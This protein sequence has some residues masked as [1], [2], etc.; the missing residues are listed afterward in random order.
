[1]AGSANL[2]PSFLLGPRSAKG[3]RRLDKSACL[4]RLKPGPQPYL[5]NRSCAMVSLY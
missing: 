4:P 5:L 1:M 2:F 3:A